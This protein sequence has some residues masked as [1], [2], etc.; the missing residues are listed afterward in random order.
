MIS[1][2][3]A[4]KRGDVC[5]VKPANDDD[6]VA[7]AW[8]GRTVIIEREL[9]P[10]GNYFITGTTNGISLDRT[11]IRGMDLVLKGATDVKA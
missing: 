9:Y 2:N 8:K 4:F 11:S 6:S 7:L 3:A 10:G 5:I 1:K